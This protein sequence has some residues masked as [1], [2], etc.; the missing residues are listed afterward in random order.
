[1]KILNH[2]LLLTLFC[3]LFISPAFAS[4]VGEHKGEDIGTGGENGG[5]TSVNDGGRNNGKG[6]SNTKIDHSTGRGDDSHEPNKKDSATLPRETAIVKFHTDGPI[7]PNLLGTH[8]FEV[9]RVQEGKVVEKVQLKVEDQLKET[10]KKEIDNQV[11]ETFNYN[12][13]YESTERRTKP[14][15]STLERETED[16]R[17]LLE[18][19]NIQA[20]EEQQK[21]ELQALEQATKAFQELQM[22]YAKVV[23]SMAF[24][25]SALEEKTENAADDRRK[26]IQVSPSNVQV[27]PSF[28]NG[29]LQVLKKISMSILSFIVGDSGENQTGMAFKRFFDGLRKK[30]PKRSD[31]YVNSALQTSGLIPKKELNPIEPAREKVMSISRAFIAPNV[32]IQYSQD[33]KKRIGPRSFDCSGFVSYIYNKAG[34]ELSKANGGVPTV[35][36]II[37]KDGMFHE[38]DEE[39]AKIGD[40]IVH[41]GKSNHVGIY[42]GKDE[43][44]NI[45]EISATT[46]NNYAKLDPSNFMFKTSIVEHPPVHIGKSWH[47]YRW[48]K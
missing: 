6:G 19:A 42:S 10:V 34:L 28:E 1:M 30:S 2:R 32:N 27:P 21:K 40:L 7:N 4:A 25:L 22:N 9:A 43:Q 16:L 44:G 23:E 29:A 24:D 12:A 20:K 11:D 45:K 3:F 26:N 15:N 33:S 5:G 13:R 18:N 39:D 14:L 48:N 17:K 37:A 31:P 47:F 41:T 8:I 38:I 46:R 35:R 36:D